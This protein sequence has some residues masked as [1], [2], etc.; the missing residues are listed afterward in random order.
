MTD[1]LVEIKDI[2]DHVMRTSFMTPEEI[3]EAVSKFKM[4]YLTLENKEEF[5]PFMQ[6]YATETSE[7]DEY[8]EERVS[9]LKNEPREFLSSKKSVNNS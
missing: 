6:T 9:Y 3:E 1:T 7:N 2:L 4:A 5:L 8:I